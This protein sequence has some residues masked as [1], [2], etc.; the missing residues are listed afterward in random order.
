MTQD[1]LAAASLAELKDIYRGRRCFILGNGPSLNQTDL[2]LLKD[3]ITIGLNRIYLKF[4]DMGFSTTFLCC[5]NELVLQQFADDIANQSSVT[6]I[7]SKGR[8][9]GPAGKSLHHMTSITGAGF[10]T[11]LSQHTW[12]PGATVTYA[13]LQLAFH[14]GIEEVIL[15]GVDHNFVHSGR[16]HLTEKASGP[17]ANHFD[18]NYFGKDILWQFPDLAESEINYATAREV[19]RIHNRRIFDATVNGKLRIFERIS[20]YALPSESIS[21]APAQA[22]PSTAINAQPTADKQD[23]ADRR[24]RIYERVLNGHHKVSIQIASGVTALVGVAMVLAVA[25]NNPALLVMLLGTGFLAVGLM[26]FAAA[27]T[28]IDW[29]SD[30]SRRR[31]LREGT[32]FLNLLEITQPQTRGDE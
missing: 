8:L 22:T 14:L 32:S 2:A 9:H 28:G 24:T 18:P 11:D 13:A 29:I 19:F 5:V 10:T 7:N 31:R 20:G 6:L 27:T 16:A 21:D 17:D 30:W 1:Q 25:I 23:S 26:A 12:H 15:L 3:E 4:P